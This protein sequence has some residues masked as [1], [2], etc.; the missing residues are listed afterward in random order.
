MKTIAPPT[1]PALL[2]DYS[3][4]SHGRIQVRKQTQRFG[5]QIRA[6]DCVPHPSLLVGMSQVDS[7][8]S[9]ARFVVRID[10]DSGEIWDAAN[11]TGLL[12]RLEQPCWPS[13]DDE[14]PL[15]IRWTVDHSGSALIPRLHLGDEE[16]LYPAQLFRGDAPFVAF[17]GHDLKDASNADLFSKG[18]VWC[19]D[20]LR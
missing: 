10:M 4:R 5:F 13:Q 1:W 17:S 14:H 20:S 3:I 2:E 18:Y 15:V 19:Q 16:F 9:T 12:G 7:A 11:G 8:G 6:G